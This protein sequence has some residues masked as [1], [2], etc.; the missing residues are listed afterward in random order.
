MSALHIAV[1]RQDKAMVRYLLDLPIK[2]LTID[3]ATYAGFTPY[4]ICY[5]DEIRTMLEGAGAEKLPHA[6]D[7]LD[8]SMDETSSDEEDE[9]EVRK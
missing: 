7:E 3:I 2:A 1:E 4:Q 9:E 6:E 8:M 5:N